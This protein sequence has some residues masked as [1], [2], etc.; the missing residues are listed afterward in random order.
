MAKL[1][2]C[3][4]SPWF[5]RDFWNMKLNLRYIYI[6]LLYFLLLFSPLPQLSFKF[7]S[8]MQCHVFSLFH[9]VIWEV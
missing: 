5:L 1:V 3:H 8:F 9:E 4:S 6:S 7:L 2:V